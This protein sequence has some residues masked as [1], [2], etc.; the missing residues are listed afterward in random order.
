MSF[1]VRSWVCAFRQRSFLQ[2][3]CIVSLSVSSTVV[4]PMK[5]LGWVVVASL[6]IACS[7]NVSLT[8]MCAL[9]HS[10]ARSAAALKRETVPT[11]LL[12][13]PPH[14]LGEASV[15]PVMVGTCSVVSCHSALF[16]RVFIFTTLWSNTAIDG[17]FLWPP[18]RLNAAPGGT[19][20]ACTGCQF[21]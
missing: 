17:K 16:S 20:G 14:V 7:A 6:S 2:A 19:R 9:H 15:V 13:R 10:A 1:L 4:I 3:S 5:N 12:T 8:L 18:E 11:G 21:L